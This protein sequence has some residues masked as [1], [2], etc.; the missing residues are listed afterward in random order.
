MNLCTNSSVN[1]ISGCKRSYNLANLS[2]WLGT[3]LGEW[4]GSLFGNQFL[5]SAAHVYASGTQQ[6]GLQTNGYPRRKEDERFPPSRSNGDV[7]TYVEVVKGGKVQG[8]FSKFPVERRRIEDKTDLKG[9]NLGTWE[10]EAEDVAYLQRCVVGSV[11]RMEHVDSIQALISAG[12]LENCEIKMLGGKDILIN[13]ESKEEA[14]NVIQN[15]VHGI[16]FWVKDLQ[17]WSQGFRAANRL[18]WLRI[19]GIPLHIWKVEV[20]KEIANN[21]GTVVTTVNCDL[22]SCLNLMWGKKKKMVLALKARSEITISKSLERRRKKSS[23]AEESEKEYGF[24]SPKVKDPITFKERSFKTNRQE[25]LV[26]CDSRSDSSSQA[27]PG[28]KAVADEDSPDYSSEPE[29]AGACVGDDRSRM[30]GNTI[31]KE[32][33]RVE[34]SK[35]DSNGIKEGASGPGNEMDNGPNVN[36]SPIGEKLG[37]PQEGI[38]DIGPVELAKGWLTFPVINPAPGG[39]NCNSPNQCSQETQ[40]SINSDAL[41]QEKSKSIRKKKADAGVIRGKSNVSGNQKSKVRQAEKPGFG[42]GRASFHC[43]KQLARSN[44]KK[45]M[46][47]KQGRRVANSSGDPDSFE[48]VVSI[49]SD[50]KGDGLSENIEEFGSK[51]GVLWNNSDGQK[52][53]KNFLAV[54]GKWEKKD[55]L[56]GCVN[57]YGPNDLR[58]RAILWSKLDQLC[59]K[60]EVSWVFFGDFNEVR[61][62]QERLNS[63]ASKKGMNDFNDF[64]RR[65]NLEDFSLGG[66]KFT[67]I[68]DDGRKFSKLDRFLASKSFGELW[69]N[70]NAGTLEKKWS[71]HLPILLRDKL[72]DFGP[73]PFKLYD[74]WLNED[75]VIN[76]V[77]EAW[78][79][80][81]KSTRPDCIFR[82]KLKRVK[83]ALK[84]WKRDNWGALDKKVALARQEVRLWEDNKDVSLLKEADRE[85]WVE[86]RKK[87]LELEE[88]NVAMARQRAKLKWAKEGDENSKLFHAASKLRERRNRIQ[89]LNIQGSWSENPEDIKKYVFEFFKKKFENTNHVGAKLKMEKIKK[90]SVEEAL[91]L[92]R[93]FTEDEV[94]GALKDC[95]GHKSPGPDGF[96]ITFLKKFWELIKGD[97]MAALDWFWEEEQ[98]SK[99]CNSSFVTLIP[100]N[101]NPIGLNDFRP[102]SLVGILYKVISKVLAERMK[103]VMGKIISN[104]Q[105]AFIKG[106]SILDGVLVANETV[107]YLKRSKRKGL[108]FKV[109]FEKAYDSVNWGFLLDVLE[110]MGFGVKWRKWVGTCLK[111]ARVSILVNGSPTEEFLMEKGIRQG[112]PLAPFLFLVVAEGLHILVEEAIEK[113]RWHN[114]LDSHFPTIANRHHIKS[115]T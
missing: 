8:S 101:T 29:V 90:V 10:A 99:G 89:G 96:S 53:T 108:I 76:L 5:L 42:R 68:S 15:K 2:V 73:I 91:W 60:E 51:I 41:Q 18:V 13:F 52:K 16:H 47:N 44:Q 45:V 74:I 80:R 102:I 12:T 26:R 35:A 50:L 14:E 82:D 30:E 20:F 87:W 92:E 7:R 17:L 31:I 94:W 88:K 93:K 70:L 19:V 83:E 32:V 71:D 24:E 63:E 54:I 46:K 109:D 110:K 77:K 100:K 58:E 11:A 85:K 25:D 43:F 59:A 72:D 103:T 56:I 38:I 66:N 106:R 112:D 84:A 36:V 107:A 113:V 61:N 9:P 3:S 65:N 23:V 111:T 86:A 67:R 69:K 1:C 81:S 105:S 49:S 75:A 104:E 48:K 114:P 40:K 6:S 79:G 21:W 64:I 98:L 55:G 37:G 78:Q 27:I 33:N 28:K 39:S 22:K 62:P 57:V 97:L 115:G 34:S 4:I 95:G